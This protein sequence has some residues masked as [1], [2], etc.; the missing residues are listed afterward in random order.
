MQL[1]IARVLSCSKSVLLK[2]A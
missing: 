1:G 2:H